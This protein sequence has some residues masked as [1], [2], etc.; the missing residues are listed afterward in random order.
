MV[1]QEN[2][3]HQK[4][5]GTAVLK[6]AGNKRHTQFQET[7]FTIILTVGRNEVLA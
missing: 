6:S 1:L 3:N 5:L 4:R 2:V 7:P